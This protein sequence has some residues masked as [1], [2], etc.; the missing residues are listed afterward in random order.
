MDGVDPD[1]LEAARTAAVGVPGVGAAEVRARWMGRTLAV[2]V[3]TRLDDGLSLLDA[4]GINAEVE[5]AVHAAVP[6]AGDVHAHAHA[7]RSA[8]VPADPR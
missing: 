5:R 8:P 1:D 6:D 2:E 7:A 4:D 3:E